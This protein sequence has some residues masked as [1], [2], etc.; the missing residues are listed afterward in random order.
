[1]MLEEMRDREHAAARARMEGE[2][3]RVAKL[4]EGVGIEQAM[5]S[6][7]WKAGHRRSQGKSNM[8][9]EVQ[10][11]NRARRMAAA[12]F[13][14][15][16]PEGVDLKEIEKAIPGFDR[17]DKDWLRARGHFHVVRVHNGRGRF[18]YTYFPGRKPEGGQC[19]DLAIGNM[20]K[21]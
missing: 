11:V 17:G 6:E 10:A 1:M 4:V 7:E 9:P 14:A 12:E 20:T 16:H 21:R 2:K 18:R 5:R 19:A 8:G 15:A 13:I 3:A